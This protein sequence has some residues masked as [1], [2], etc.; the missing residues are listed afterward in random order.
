VFARLILI[1]AVRRNRE[2]DFRRWFHWSV[3]YAKQ[4]GLPQPSLLKEREG[5]GYAIL[6]E[7]ESY[8]EL[9]TL[10]NHPLRQIAQLR[11]APL[12][13]GE[14]IPGFYYTA[15]N[16][17]SR[18]TS[19]FVNLV[20]FP[21]VR[22]GKDSAFRE[23]FWRSGDFC[24]GFSRTH[25]RRLLWPMQ[26]GNYAAVLEH[27]GGAAPAQRQAGPGW[28]QA[29]QWTRPLLDGDL[30]SRSFERLCS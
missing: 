2:S 21:P 13:D 20:F 29:S 14:A 30:R 8:G 26:G 18:G 12:L 3:G 10:L 4:L 22:Q 5:Q 1:P 19:R 11:V 15:L 6:E 16:V 9:L 17:G 23:W 24:A 7:Q 25:R 27:D 28:M